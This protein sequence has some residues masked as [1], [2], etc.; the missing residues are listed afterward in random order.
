MKSTPKR[1]LLLIAAV[2]MLAVALAACGGGGSS[3]GSETTDTSETPSEP[4]AETTADE[5]GGKQQAAAFVAPYIG[6]PSPFPVTEKLKEVPK[7]ATIAYM[8]CGDPVCALVY[9]L[10]EGAAATMGVKLEHIKTGTAANTVSAA[11]DSVVAK[12]PDAVISMA[13]PVSLWSKQLVQLQQ[14]GI[15]VIA[16]GVAGKEAEEYE[17]PVGASGTTKANELAGELLANY[18]AAKMTPNANVTF[19]E[20]AGVALTKEVEETFAPDLEAVCPGC[21]VRTASVAQASLGS[22]APNEVVSDLQA[23]PDTNVAVFGADA[24]ELGLPNALHAAGIDVET[25]GYGPN[26]P[27]LEAIKEGTETAGLASDFPVTVWALLDQTAREIVGQELT[28]LEAEGIGVLQ[29]L[30]KEDITFDPSKG[31]TG[32]PDF[33]ERFAKLWGVE[34]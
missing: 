10:L 5:S 34:G 12:K 20:V 30:T 19:Y 25:L 29:F 18:V 7:G 13:T 31:W 6:K 27:N 17:V 26:P 4:T 11:W 33:A 32:Y 16:E 21:S 23:N 2:V 1:V 24:I 8:D 15:P 14:A 22:T 9:E 28:G 3:T